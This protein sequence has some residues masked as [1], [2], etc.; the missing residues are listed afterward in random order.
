MFC[1]SI[2]ILIL[3]VTNQVGKQRGS[4]QEEVDILRIQEFFTMN[5]LRF[6]G[7]STTKDP[8]NFIEELRRLFE[9][10]CI[11][12][13]EQVGLV[14][15]QVKNVV[16]T[17]FDQWKEGKDE[18]EPDVSSA[19]FKEA[20]LGCLFARE[21]KEAKV[22]EIFTINEKSLCI[23]KYGSKFTN[24]QVMLRRRLNI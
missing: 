13:T 11:A 16:M 12:D 23:H 3:D 9:V 7:S 19:C 15:F 1:E 22:W 6:T 2:G 20:F 10:M 4:R 21:L 5:P 18:Y 24:L 8:E 17:W 14:A